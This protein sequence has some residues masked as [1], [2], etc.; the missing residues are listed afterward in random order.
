[1][2][3]ALIPA[4]GYSRRFGRPKL[5]LPLGSTTVL[6]HVI[7]AIQAAGVERVLVVAAS[8][9][10]ELVPLAKGAGAEAVLLP[11]ETPGMR[12]T[13]EFGLRWIDQMWTP[14]P[15]DA[16]LLVPGD[17]PLLKPEVIH[18]LQAA[19]QQQA[20]RSIFLPV[21]EGRRGHPALISWGQVAQILSY[22]ADLGLNCYLREQV[23]E[24]CEVPVC[25]PSILVDLDTPADY[26]RILQLH[27]GPGL[28]DSPSLCATPS[29]RQEQ[30]PGVRDLPSPQR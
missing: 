19:R 15:T 30:P 29:L 23:A 27:S 9:L 21:Y 6:G 17:H 11:Q 22:P 7:A 28:T 2:I 26:E 24:T 3:V 1:M 18:E 20:R 4:G 16:W 13:V 14:A 12:A 5:L 25:D 8:H 10:P